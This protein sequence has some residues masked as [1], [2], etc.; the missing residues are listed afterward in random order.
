MGT[1]QDYKNLADSCHKYGLKLIIDVVP[2]HCGS[3]HWWCQDLPAE[4][5][6]HKWP[7]FTG[8]NYRMTAWTDPHASEIDKKILKDGWFAGNMPDLDLNNPELFRY[9]SQAYIWW[10]E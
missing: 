2:N 10:I 3:S 4:D 5:W 6:F 7:T 9:L 8:S 1:N